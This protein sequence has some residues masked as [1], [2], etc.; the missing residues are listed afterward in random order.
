M[1]SSR[2]LLIFA[3]LA[4]S[5]MIWQQWQADYGPQPQTNTET[6][7]NTGITSTG[8]LPQPV[9]PDVDTPSIADA[10][11]DT[12]NTDVPTLLP[13]T[14][15]SS[16]AVASAVINVTTDVLDLDISLSGGA[17][18]KSILREYP[19]DLDNPEEKVQLFNSDPNHYYVAQLGLVSS[20][21]AVPDHNTEWTSNQLAF[22]MGAEET[23]TVPLIWEN[24]SVRIERTYQFTRGSY[25]IT[26]EEQV[27]NKTNE[28]I[29][30]LPYRQFHRVDPYRNTDPGFTNPETFSFTGIA[31]YDSENNYEKFDFDELQDSDLNREVRQGWVA[32]IQHYFVSAWIPDPNTTQKI[33]GK[34]QPQTG[35]PTRY[36]VRQT[37][38]VMN[39]PA[40]GTQ[41]HSLQL[42]TGPKI[43]EQLSKVAEGLDLSVDYGILTPFSA[44]LFWVLQRLY[45]LLGNWGWSIVAVTVLI[46]L[47]FYKLSEAQY[48]SMAKMRKM[49]PRMQQ[50]K[51]RYGDDKQKLNQE[52]MAMYKKEK[53]NPLGGCLPILVQIPVFIALYWVL[54]ESV[55][56]RQAPFML[57]IQ[58]LS[59]PDPYYVL[60]VLNGI[61][62]VI[63]QKLSPNP[64]MD[65]M[66]QKIMMAMPVAFSVLF[67][68]FPAGL[69]LYW[70]TN[71]I[72]SLAQ[73]WVITKRIEAS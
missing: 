13:A 16:T 71:S 29:T 39:I 54:L 59:K 25:A 49:Q 34:I 14:G 18:T 31:L 57:W 53:I 28:N 19:V 33:S 63:T 58:N 73:Q 66:Q 52:M 26:I 72:L 3:L 40:G 42:F 4:C 68:F 12:G 7:S 8:D 65:P 5:F 2:P 10:A 60:P 43:Q 23:L 61:A 56:L 46:K 48:R 70:A 15:N 44:V 27:T 6:N 64:G 62:M 24:D 69:V 67:A 9:I 37:A 35:Q 51:D 17:L 45:W 38:P 20:G 55:E 47:A 36:R 11:T 22:D 30:V 21:P 41:S 32:M 1:N 50:L